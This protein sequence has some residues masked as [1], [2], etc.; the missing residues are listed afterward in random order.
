MIILFVIE[1]YGPE[2][3]T[4]RTTLCYKRLTAF[5][6]TVRMC[7]INS[8]TESKKKQKREKGQVYRQPQKFKVY[9]IHP[10]FLYIIYTEELT[11]LSVT[12]PTPNIASTQQ[13]HKQYYINV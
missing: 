8:K 11:S 12:Y 6:S 2:G 13:S 10:S 1:G 3:N 5:Q 4:P 9:Y 7:Q